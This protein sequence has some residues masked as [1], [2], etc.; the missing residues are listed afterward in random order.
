[1]TGSP[2]TVSGPDFLHHPW[3]SDQVLAD[4]VDGDETSQLCHTHKL[5]GTGHRLQAVSL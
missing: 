4:N 2:A 1:M 3:L 5:P